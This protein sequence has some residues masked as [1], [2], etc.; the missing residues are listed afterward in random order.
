MNIPRID[1]I[2]IG[3]VGVSCVLSWSCDFSNSNHNQAESTPNQPKRLIAPAT[4][5]SDDVW[6]SRNGDSWPRFLGKN[7]DSSSTETGIL[8]DWSDGQLKVR[9]IQEVGEGYGIGS[10]ER[11]AYFHFDRVGNKAR[12]TSRDVSTGQLNW[13]YEYP[14]DYNDLYG[15]DGGPRTSPVIDD[16]RVYV[17]GV[18]GELHCVDVESGKKNWSVDTQKK[19]GVIQNFFGVGSSP[20]VYKNLLITMVGGSPDADQSIAPGSLN[21]VSSNGTGIVAFDK[22]TGEVVYQSINDLASYSSP[23]IIQ[24]DNQDIVVAWMRD[25]LVTFNPVDGTELWR[26]P[27]RARKLESVNA[28][29]PVFIGDRIFISECYGPG[30]ALLEVEAANQ[31]KVLWKDDNGRNKSMLAHFNTPV[32]DGEFLFGS[33][34]QHAG[35]AQLRCLNWKTGNVAWEQTGF[36]RSS[37]LKVD[38]HLVV[39]G[40]YGKLALVKMTAD[41]FEQVT[42]FDPSSCVFVDG[43]KCGLGALRYPCWAAPILSHGMM[44]IRDKNRV[45][46][47]DLIP[48][49]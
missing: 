26:F 43:T 7:A 6:E 33:S 10:I 14:T 35:G 13:K 49:A 37:I 12:L 48:S 39:I 28:S 19:F 18:E 47:F 41:E 34:G 40:E 5:D 22:L 38:K 8:K 23:K 46:C 29:C 30:S 3:L 27:W 45:I 42:E 2:L 17:F 20:L 15:Y 9:W 44:I 4:F 16:K 1:L 32:V 24:I 36:A 11:G 21:Q 31:F 25:N